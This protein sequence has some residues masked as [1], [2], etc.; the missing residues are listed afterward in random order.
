MPEGFTV[1]DGA[2]KTFKES[3]KKLGLDSAKAQAVLEGYVALDKQRA[4]ADEAAFQKQAAEWAK[5]VLSDPEV[6]GDKLP[7]AK[8]DVKRALDKFGGKELVGLL[9]QAGLSSHPV[10]FKTLAAIGRALKEDSVAGTAVAPKAPKKSDA[11]LF[12]FTT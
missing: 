1:D 4:Q 7:A 2:L 5:Q 6:G 10:V 12:G 8:V 3:A 11:E 9:Q